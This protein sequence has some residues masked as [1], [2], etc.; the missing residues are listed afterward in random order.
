M[1]EQ[2]RKENAKK[3]FYFWKAKLQMDVC[4]PFAYRF[5]IYPDGGWRFRRP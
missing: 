1:G 2:K 4:G 3:K 5:R